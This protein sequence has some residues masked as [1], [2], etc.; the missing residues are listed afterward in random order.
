M[1]F[2]LKIFI[3]ILKK[4]KRS[5]SIKQ[6]IMFKIK[7]N[8]IP[9]FLSF[10]FLLTFSGWIAFFKIPAFISLPAAG[11]SIIFLFLGN[12]YLN[13]KNQIRHEAPVSDSSIQNTQLQGKYAETLFFTQAINEMIMNISESDS[14]EFILTQMSSI[15]GKTIQA[16]RSLI[17]DIDFEKDTAEG[18]CEWLNPDFPGISASIGT[19]PLDFFRAGC[20]Y[21]KN[22]KI[23]LESHSNAV[24]EELLKD[25][26]SEILHN[27]MEIKSLL[28][29]PF[30]FSKNR[31]YLLFLI[32]S[33][34]YET[35]RVKSLNF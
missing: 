15:L 34:T 35:G 5:L 28:W 32:R 13:G 33:A 18:M 12:Y 30:Y 3:I 6:S 23:H 2:F 24:N 20:N 22:T 21:I 19:Y 14:V 9:L 7:S 25:G 26:S 10:L 17:Y 1:F 4:E 31:Y 8:N 11:L 16:D 29:F 27:Q